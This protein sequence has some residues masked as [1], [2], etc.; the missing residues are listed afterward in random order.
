MNIDKH[1]N[2]REVNVYSQVNMY[3]VVEMRQRIGKT[4]L[5]RSVAKGIRTRTAST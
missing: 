3:T 1:R 5:F 2:D 4:N